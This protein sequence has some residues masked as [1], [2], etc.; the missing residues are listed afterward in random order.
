MNGTG[1]YC[2]LLSTYCFLSVMIQQREITAAEGRIT[3]LEEL[4][5]KKPQKTRLMPGGVVCRPNPDPSGELGNYDVCTIPQQP[6]PVIPFPE[7]SS[8]Q[9]VRDG[10]GDR[11]ICV[12]IKPC[13]DGKP[14]E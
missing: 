5:A 11:V 10:S 3:A 14:C 13:E 1:V 2:L 9:N 6:A 4:K 7:C 8:K 12:A